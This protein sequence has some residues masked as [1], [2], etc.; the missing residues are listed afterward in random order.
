MKRMFSDIL[1]GVPF[2][3]TSPSCSLCF[4][5]KRRSGRREHNWRAALLVFV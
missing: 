1:Q 4:Y 3:E 5:D 2:A